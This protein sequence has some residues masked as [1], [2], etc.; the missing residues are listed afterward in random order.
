MTRLAGLV[1]ALIMVL[2]A[3]TAQ[4]QSIQFQLGVSNGM[5][6]N[7]MSRRGYTD[8]NITKKKLTKAQAEG[9]RNGKR[10]KVEIA[11][12]G[13][14]RKEVQIG[15]CRNPINQKAARKIL[16]DRGYNQIFVRPEG[17]GFIAVACR[18]NRRF[19]VALDPFGDIR[20]EKL[21]GRCGGA[22][23]KH[24]IAALLRARGFS[25]IDVKRG[26]RGAYA[27]EACRGDHRMKL[28]V[29]PAGGIVREQRIGRCDPP[30]HPASIPTLLAQYGFSRIDVVDRRLPRYLAH[31]CRG[32]ERLEIAM[33]RFGEISDERR[34]GRCD[35]PLNRQ[36][37]EDRLRAAG[38]TGVKI[39]GHS[40]NG[41]VADV[42]EDAELL[43]LKLTIFGETVNQKRLGDCPTR[44]VGDVVDDFQSQ[45]LSGATLFVEGCRRGRRIRIE[46][47]RTGEEVDRKTLGR[48]R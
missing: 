9:C 2:A 41:F 8:I 30:I 32:N 4:G 23:S 28:V 11:L 20:G 43:R 45:G 25:R 10:Y 18:S 26:R 5:I 46:L 13:R 3:N 34:I 16:R 38:Y 12:D 7:V 44:P 15:T 42:C 17:N 35:P 47:D 37:L 40:A 33:N 39:V 29:G 36:M 31:A 21:L 19:R 48:C 1:I 24:D 14:I 22:M 6:L 27:V